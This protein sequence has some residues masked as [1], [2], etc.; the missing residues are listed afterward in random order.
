MVCLTFGEVKANNWHDM[1]LLLCDLLITEVSMHPEILNSTECSATDVDF[2]RR[3]YADELEEDDVAITLEVL[4]RMLAMHW[5]APVVII[6]DEHDTPLQESYF[7]GFYDM[8]WV[9]KAE[10]QFR[11]G[12]SRRP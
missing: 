2:M 11:Q 8:I 12:T 9:T 4:T 5:K 10:L 3:L 1:Y 7:Y 6:I